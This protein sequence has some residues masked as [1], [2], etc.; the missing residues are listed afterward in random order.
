MK[1]AFCSLLVITL[2]ALPSI[3]SAYDTLPSSDPL[4]DAEESRYEVAAWA[5][6]DQGTPLITLRFLFEGDYEIYR[7]VSGNTQWGSPVRNFGSAISSWT[8]SEVSVGTLYEYAFRKPAVPS[9]VHLYAYNY[10]YLNAG[11]DVDQSGPRGTV[12]VA[13]AE[14]VIAGNELI[15]DRFYADLIGD[16]WE[17]DIITTPYFDNNSFS[18]DF[19]NGN[20]LSTGAGLHG[21][22][23]V[24]DLKNRIRAIYQADPD[25]VKMLY[26]LG[27]TPTAQS[28]QEVG[29]PDGHGSRGPYV[30]DSYFADLDG[31]W[32]DSGTNS[33]QYYDD[34]P[35]PPSGAVTF[36]LTLP[37]V[38]GDGIFDQN[39]M[40]SQLELA[41]GRV[42]P[43]D[44]HNGSISVTGKTH[45]ESIADYLEKVHRYRHVKPFGLEGNEQLAGRRAQIRWNPGGQMGA[46]STGT[47]FLQIF[48]PDKIEDFVRTNSLPA[49]VAPNDNED[50]QQTIDHGPFLYYGQNSAPPPSTDIGGAAVHRFS[51]QSWWGDWWAHVAS[52]QNL[53]SDT[54]MVL[55]WLYTGRFTGELRLHPL[56]SMGTF[57]EAHKLSVNYEYNQI[58]QGLNVAP[59]NGE[60][61][62]A[63]LRDLVGDPTLR[64]FPVEPVSD[65]LATKDRESVLLNWSAPV[66]TS[67]LVGYRVLRA[68]SLTDSFTLLDGNVSG[69]SFTDNAPLSGPAIYQV[70]AVH[71]VPTG[72]GTFRTNAQGLFTHV[73]MKLDTLILPKFSIGAEVDFDFAASQGE[74]T[75]LWS[76]VDGSLPEGLSLAADGSLTGTPIVAGEFPIR[77]AAVDD[78]GTPIERS[79][80]LFVDAAFTE[81]MNVDLRS[82]GAGL[83]DKTQFDRQFTVR[84]D[85]QM[86]ASSMSFN[87][88]TDA[89]QIHNIGYG[90]TSWPGWSFLPENLSKGNGFALALS[91]KAPEASRPRVL[92]AKARNLSDN[93]R[94]NESEFA[95]HL[96]SNGRLSARLWSRSITS[97]SRFDDDQWH[98][99]VFLMRGDTTELYVNGQSMGTRGEGRVTIDEDFLI[100]ARWDESG[101]E[102]RDLFQGEI[103]DVTIYRTGITEGEVQTLYQRANRARLGT[104][105]SPPELSRLPSL[106][107]VR[108]LDDS[109]FV[110]IPFN[111]TDADGH[112]LKVHHFVE[113]SDIFLFRDIL[114]TESGYELRLGFSPDFFGRRSLTVFA[115]DQW[116][117]HTT[118]HEI[119]IVRSGPDDD[120]FK[121]GSNGGLLD[122]LAN[123]VARVGLPQFDAIVQQPTSGHARFDEGYLEF[124][125]APGWNE[126]VS[127]QYRN[128][129]SGRAATVSITP[130]NV[131]TPNNDQ[132]DLCEGIPVLLDVLAND[133]DPGSEDLQPVIVVTPTLG[134]ARIT[135]GTIEYT[136]P[137]NS[138]ENSTSF[139]YHVRNTSGFTQSARAWVTLT[140]LQPHPL[141]LLEFDSGTSESAAKTGTLTSLSDATIQGSYSRVSGLSGDALV[142]NGSDTRID[143]GS[144]PELNFNPA[145]DSFSIMMAVKFN[146]GD[147]ILDNYYT[148]LSKNTQTGDSQFAIA[149]GKDP[150]KAS[151]LQNYPSV[152]WILNNSGW[153]AIDEFPHAD[154]FGDYEKVWNW[155]YLTEDFDDFDA[156][157]RLLTFIHDASTQTSQVYVDN[158]LVARVDTSNSDLDSGSG[159]GGAIMLG[160]RPDG[161]G[162]Y[163]DFFDGEIDAVRI[164]DR[165]LN[166]LEIKPFLAEYGFIDDLAPTLLDP[167]IIP[168]LASEFKAGET[169]T[170]TVNV[171]DL[172]SSPESYTIEPKVF[173]AGS[174][175]RDD[176]NFIEITMPESGYFYASFAV[177]P[178][179]P[180]TRKIS[181]NGG[182]TQITV[183][184]TESLIYPFRIISPA[185]LGS[186][187]TGENF[188]TSIQ[189]DGSAVS[190]FNIV[191]GSLPH[192][193]SLDEATGAITG[194]PTTAGRFSFKVIARSTDGR[195]SVQTCD[196]EIL[197]AD[198]NR[199]RIPDS[200]EQA[201]LGHLGSGR[202]DDPEGNGLPTIFDFLLGIDGADG[203]HS[204][205]HTQFFKG[206]PVA[207]D[208]CWVSLVLQRRS[209]AAG[210]PLSIMQ[211]HDLS[212]WTPIADAPTIIEDNGDMQT[213]EAQVPF[214][215]E[216]SLFFRLETD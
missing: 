18:R 63:F 75:V 171:E 110:S 13:I 15:L 72:S 178:P 35:T 137:E 88:T 211:S 139:V 131:P 53:F 174:T 42:D 90:T 160:A 157:W 77:V 57:G 84:G 109:S 49:A 9:L 103:A 58:L 31:I 41:Y 123:D 23:A 205:M 128:V 79:F 59:N 159:N 61:N 173:G 81:V 166:P 95:I 7:R 121:V 143:L 30:A 89:I 96:T 188:V 43:M 83:I 181:A 69:T 87:G 124:I 165:A 175:L 25:G 116:P 135:N 62:D 206:R 10:G 106:I 129:G 136:P 22:D 3:V 29:H 38:P 194:N 32:T 216:P 153:N 118:T 133:T 134:A 200:W 126:P 101:S 152:W 105:G 44:N 203:P 151:F 144:P 170:F 145:T 155:R 40:P 167:P 138:I 93:W 176:T 214:G 142:F 156:D 2:A 147:D 117:G 141:V 80:S 1:S 212:S 71:R 76:L 132:F 52:R 119:E 162:G 148:L 97:T 26:F 85:P 201:I 8:D 28:G 5:E 114:A 191:S 168:D 180:M 187:S 104:A 161:N 130:S 158:R 122:I 73:G 66:E 169:Y 67:E 107:D 34:H 213:L 11:I 68:R 33:P 82:T 125:P 164:W 98:H 37:N 91:F 50:V 111:A 16:G 192:G 113:D 183:S 45:A 12:I 198:S 20:Y 46:I 100:G 195:R 21:H 196:I 197:A 17:V 115:D 150:G 193:I 47:Y 55:T 4:P 208:A 86:S 215:G 185:D 179:V 199:N 182:W 209:D 78:S 140:Y 56:G 154:D 127:L 6:I 202:A 99:V 92:L 48:G 177:V 190:S 39:T 146:V 51:M 163:T 74:G 14:N 65:L 207:D 186:G 70:Q 149:L 36:E 108:S 64:M 102:L 54:N 172:D 27:H 120:A 24:R 19:A 210:N 184:E 94:E 112:P 204:F 189:T 60:V